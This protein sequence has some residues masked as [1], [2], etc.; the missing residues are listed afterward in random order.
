[1][2]SADPRFTREPHTPSTKANGASHV[3]EPPP[4]FFEDEA[5][6]T[7][8]HEAE[9]TGY[10]SATSRDLPTLDDLMGPAL[11]RAERRAS[12]QEK[13]I[14]LA[15][16]ML[17]EHFGG[18]VWPGVH[19][20]ISLTGLGK[21]TWA[22]Q[23]SL[24]S[25]RLNVPVMYIGLELEPLQ[26]TL[27]LLAEEAG[28]AWSALYTGKAGPACF[29][30]ARE[31]IPRLCG[32]PL[33]LEFARP[34]GW[35]VSELV[36]AAEALRSKYPEPSEAPGSRP[37]LIV[38][39]YLQIVGAETD[40]SGRPLD[41]RE[42]IG[43]ASYVCRDVASRLNAGVLVVSSTARDKYGLLSEACG[44]AGLV[45]DESEAGRPINRRVLRP[46]A[47]VGLGKESGEI[48]FSA[49]SVSV[50]AR[51]P[52]TERER[53]CDVLFVTAKGRA[54]GA[55][56]SP[57]HFTGHR[58]VEADDGG[59]FTLEAMKASETARGTKREQKRQA[60]EQAKVDRAIADAGAV[61]KYVREHPRCSVR[62]ARSAVGDNFRR[63]TPA[64]E[65]LGRALL[66]SD[67]LS[68]DEAHLPAEVRA[69]LT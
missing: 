20:V 64:V 69:C 62:A 57:L 31:A 13:P 21:T 42:R 7:E 1:V 39:D 4:G 67:G 65:K 56:W 14:P 29:A 48:E 28:L 68:L 66:T 37:M 59:S 41:L 32:L 33:H 58:Y 46:D 26:I 34:Q 11:E 61:A 23:Q 54:T 63:W 36:G 51:V 6:D 18:G 53:G 45:C 52:G 10:P 38:L 40:A 8:P 30:R 60:K 5:P 17:A 3:D 9:A 55:T 50:M 47:L 22:L 16:P 15:W 44:A 43:R 24:Y 25:A 2:T 35:P 27:R 19:F 49:D 12:G